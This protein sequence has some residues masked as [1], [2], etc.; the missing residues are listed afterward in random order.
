MGKT[1]GLLGTRIPKPHN[2]VVRKL[3]TKQAIEMGMN[4]LWTQILIRL[5]T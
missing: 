4:V 2:G 3:T 1:S 5:A